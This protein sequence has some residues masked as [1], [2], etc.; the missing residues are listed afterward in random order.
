MVGQTKKILG[1]LLEQQIGV[2]K[3]GDNKNSRSG[4]IHSFGDDTKIDLYVDKISRKEV[5]YSI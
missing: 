1:Q 5:K 4:F 3:L 2:Q